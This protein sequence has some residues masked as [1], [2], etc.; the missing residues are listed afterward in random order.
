MKTDFEAKTSKQEPEA[1]GHGLAGVKG[2]ADKG[3]GLWGGDSAAAVGAK[4]EVEDVKAVVE[5]G[6]HACAK[7]EAEAEAEAEVN[8]AAGAKP[9]EVAVESK[10]E[11]AG[12]AGAAEA[13]EAAEAAEAVEAAE[14]AEGVE[15]GG[16]A[17]AVEAAEAAEAAGVH[18]AAASAATTCNPAEAPQLGSDAVNA[19]PA[20]SGPVQTG[21]PPPAQ[22]DDGPPGNP[23][24]AVAVGPTRGGV[25]QGGDARRAASLLSMQ[26]AE[27]EAMREAALAIQR[28]PHGGLWVRGMLVPRGAEAIPTLWK[29]VIAGPLRG[30][31]TQHSGVLRA[32]SLWVRTDSAWYWLRQSTIFAPAT[33][34]KL[35][36]LPPGS[37]A[38]C[39]I[40]E[41]ALM[42][43]P[44]AFVYARSVAPPSRGYGVAH[45]P[46]ASL[47]PY[48]ASDALDAALA[49]CPRS[50][51]LSA[52][53][54]QDGSGRAVDLFDELPAGML[55]AGASNALAKPLVLLGQLLPSQSPPP[56][57]DA[58]T[59][60]VWPARLWL[61]SLP[62][63]EW[64][65]QLDPLQR[66]GG[67]GPASMAVGP[68]RVWVRSGLSWFF[69]S[70][71]KV[72]ASWRPPGSRSRPVSDSQLTE[73]F[74]S[75][76][77]P[78]INPDGLPCRVITHFAVTDAAGT[79]R[80]LFDVLQS[81]SQP[82]AQAFTLRGVVLP[83]GSNVSVALR[84]PSLSATRSQD[85]SGGDTHVPFS[86][87]AAEKGVW[88]CTGKIVG[89]KMDYGVEPLA[90]WVRT[91]AAMYRVLLPAA[92]YAPLFKAPGSAR[93]N[94]LPESALASLLELYRR[95][96][97]HPFSSKKASAASSFKLLN[98]EVCDAR[99]APAEVLR[100][101]PEGTLKASQTA[102]AA[103]A[104]ANSGTSGASQLHVFLRGQLLPSRP[105]A[106]RPWLWVG[107]VRAWAADY[108]KKT[109]DGCP[110]PSSP[111]APT[112][113]SGTD[114]DPPTSGLAPVP[115]P[116]LSHLYTALQMHIQ[117]THHLS[118][119]VLLRW[120]AGVWPTLCPNALAL[121]HS[122]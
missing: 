15:A 74:E 67:T 38:A 75:S 60:E 40:A 84:T 97:E 36:W 16:A 4:W 46:V 93:G 111:C 71:P 28:T 27:A 12:V 25:G 87:D 110:R 106:A 22:R 99:A 112:T 89:G 70:K 115:V 49:I 114:P 2:T 91:E 18:Q 90:M 31:T 61:R 85:G 98:F 37:N 109:P 50:F 81:C 73:A 30:W 121:M 24:T 83:S 62:V 113:G 1:P 80:P 79:P 41:D 19:A 54:L 100:R 32:Q 103:A 5:S 95:D 34:Y 45:S 52:F 122:A 56:S 10:M 101:L 8:V 9:S 35:L 3:E 21:P 69:L 96:E 42:A 94:P 88:V 55:Q 108:D 48:L 14:A 68:A 63:Q 7:I 105:G 58:A 51:R 29:Y 104:G 119:P 72:E 76:E 17:E 39:A 102:A 13:V 120:S 78:P 116:T 26:Q 44:V 66:G 86:E 20:V 117:A 57:T 77:R 92:D 33:L 43:S 47:P 65:L 11:V 118:T 107:P 6:S 64:R 82:G 59:S 23:G 53:V